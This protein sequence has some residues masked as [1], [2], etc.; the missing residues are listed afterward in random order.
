[1]QK[2]QNATNYVMLQV[3]AAAFLSSNGIWVRFSTLG[4]LNTGNL[5]TSHWPGII[6]TLSG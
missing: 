1:M 5:P 6:C 3:I 2:R 4:L